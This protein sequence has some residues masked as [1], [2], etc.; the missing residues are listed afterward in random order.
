MEVRDIRYFKAV[1]EHRNIGRAAEALDLSATALSKSLRRL[2][3]DL[4]AKLVK[5]TSRGVELTT[6]G[7]ALAARANA[8]QLNLDDLAREAADLTAGVLGSVSVTCPPGQCEHCIA[9]AFTVLLTETV[10]VSLTTLVT[11]R[12]QMWAAL[13]SGRA[14]FIVNSMRPVPL[15]RPGIEC[16][17]L[18]CV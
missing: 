6:V 11:D 15:R 7:S 8:L 17:E 5:R 9:D 10:N 13:R 12:E 4:G 16:E 3:R 2:E 1:A 18:F 14:D